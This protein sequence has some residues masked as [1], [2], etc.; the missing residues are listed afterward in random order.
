MAGRAHIKDTTP[1]NL[2][3]MEASILELL[4]DGKSADEICDTLNLKKTTYYSYTKH[5]REKLCV[6]TLQEAVLNYRAAK[7][8]RP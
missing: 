2:T 3:R 8:K 6:D 5:A 1:F 7:A 4:G